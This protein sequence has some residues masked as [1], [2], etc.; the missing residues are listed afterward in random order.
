MTLSPLPADQQVKPRHFEFRMSVM[1]AALFVAPGV[2]LPYFPLWLEHIGFSAAQI[3]IILSVPM[4][5]RMATTPYVTAYADRASD[6]V[7]VLLLVVAA[8]LFLS[9]GYFLPPT[10]VI[11]LTVSVLLAVVWTPHV[12]VV[13]SIALSGVRRYRSNYSLMRVWGSSSFL[14]ANVGGGVILA[15]YGVTAV[16]VMIVV[17]LAVTLATVAIVPRLGRPRVASPLSASGLQAAAPALLNRPFVLFVAGAGFINASHGFQFGFVSIYWKSIGIS[18]ATVGA[19]WAWSV[20]AEVV[21]FFAF[22]RVFGRTSATRL[23]AYAGIAAMVRWL[24][25]PFILPAGLGVPGYFAVQTLHALSTGLILIGVQ[26]MIAEM[27]SENRTG[28]AQGVA[29]FANGMSMAAITL[30]SGP[31]FAAF[32]VHGFFAMVAVA[33]FG[34]VLVIFGARAQPQRAGTGGDTSDPL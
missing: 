23:I 8:S 6:R 26:K 27:V 7:N 13:D 14:A 34:V 22:T 32:G 2:H 29:F 17:G 24:V 20:M 11:V 33:A 10:Y 21:M 19:L 18:E 3:A 30:V 31:L 4:F 16:P 25:L 9:L 15:A 5:A 12:L 28:A 1:Y